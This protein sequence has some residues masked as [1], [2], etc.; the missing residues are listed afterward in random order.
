M[1]KEG[2]REQGIHYIIKIKGFRLG[3]FKILTAVS[4]VISASH[5]LPIINPPMKN[6]AVKD[7]KSLKSFEKQQ[8][9]SNN[10][11]EIIK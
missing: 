6:M 2:N 7:F 1:V 9:K 11:E 8:R 5:V 10:F 4:V 3:N